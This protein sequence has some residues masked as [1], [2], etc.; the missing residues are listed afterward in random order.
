[1]IKSYMMIHQRRIAAKNWKPLCSELFNALPQPPLTF[2]ELLEAC[3]CTGHAKPK[4]CH[5][6][7]SILFMH[8]L[9]SLVKIS[10]RSLISILVELLKS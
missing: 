7:A 6:P 9:T 2:M 10:S 4:I 8:V 3:C 1:M 5:L